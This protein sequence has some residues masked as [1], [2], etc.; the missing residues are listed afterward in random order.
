MQES[1]KYVKWKEPDTNEYTMYDSI[2][3]VFKKRQN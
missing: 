2:H 3:M 1:Q